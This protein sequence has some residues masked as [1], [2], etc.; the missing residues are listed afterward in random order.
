MAIRGVAFDLDETLAVPKRDRETL[1]EEAVSATNA[2]PITRQ[3]YL[4]A[5][6][7][8]LTEETREPIFKDVLAQYDETETNPATLTAAYRQAVTEALN[9]IPGAEKLIEEL[10]ETYQVGLLTNGPIKAQREKIDRLQWNTLF[11]VALVTGE[12]PAGKPH[13]DAFSALLSE[14]GTTPEETVYIGDTPRDDIGGA[15]N[16]GMIAVQVLFSGGPEPDPRAD[17]HIDRNK[18]VLEL[19]ALLESLV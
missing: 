19:P 7:N 8:N 18:L 15:T 11:P 16:A 13:P 6:R 2:P 17:A 10:K 1:L 12:L 14:L 4:T 3:E 9:P 5:H